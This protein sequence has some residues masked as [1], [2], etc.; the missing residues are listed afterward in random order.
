MSMNTAINLL[1]DDD[2]ELNC[3]SHEPQSRQFPFD[4]LIGNLAYHAMMV[5]VHLTP[6]PGLVDTANTGA[7]KDMDINHFTKS[8]NAITPFMMQ[9]VTVGRGASS[10]TESVLLSLLRPIG[11][12]AE[13]AMFSTTNGV[14]THK[15]MIFSLGLICGA[16]GWLKGNKRA[17]SVINICATVERC[18]RGLVDKELSSLKEQRPKTQGEKLFQQY[19]VTGAR[20]EAASGFS[21]V[22]QFA[23]PTY[24]SAI[25]DGLSTEQ[26]LWQTL[27]VLMAHNQDTNLLARG[28]LDGLTYVQ[29]QAKHLLDLGGVY[30]ADIESNLTRF[31][32]ILIERNLSPGGSADLLAL[33]WLLSELEALLVRGN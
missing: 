4:R 33:T 25:N 8:A 29:L 17:I 1:L 19:G 3:G 2:L 21:T 9:C 32:H 10:L 6:K 13:K 20:G 28:G 31:D 18:C 16:V 14:N 24:R 12:E 26:A 27:L 30:H 7:H 11:I 15:G 23:L 22:S 5:E